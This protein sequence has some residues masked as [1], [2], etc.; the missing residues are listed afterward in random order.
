MGIGVGTV[1]RIVLSK[2]GGIP[3]MG[4]PSGLTVNGMPATV[5]LTISPALLV[6]LATG[7]AGG[8]GGLINS[9]VSGVT[10]NLTTS[11]N[12]SL[13]QLF[14]NPTSTYVTSATT[15]F[16]SAQSYISGYEGGLTLTSL[17]NLLNTNGDNVYHTLKV[18]EGH[19]NRLSGVA[20]ADDES[21]YVLTDVLN[22]TS[23]LDANVASNLNISVNDYTNSLNR[24]TV[25]DLLKANLALVNNA[26]TSGEQGQVDSLVANITALKANLDT[27]VSTD[28]TNFNKTLIKTDVIGSVQTLAMAYNGSSAAQNLIG[29][30][31]NAAMNTAIKAAAGQLSGV[32]GGGVKINSGSVEAPNGLYSP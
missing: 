16:T 29:A 30:V 5:Q 4:I 11:F 1:I 23:G 12:G 22:L 32:L 3:L 14:Q 28:V 9:V 24:N 6:S 2:I 18:F 8:L 31:T 13:N 21:Q 7:Q 19:T 15:E 10:N 26:I 27:T 20:V 17:S 25:I